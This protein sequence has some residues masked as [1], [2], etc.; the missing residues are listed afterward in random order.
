M[1]VTV[2]D[3]AT[4]RRPHPSDESV[5]MKACR[6]EPVPFTP[7][8]LMRQA[9]RYMK[10]Y[11]ELREQT[12][13]LDLCKSSQLVSE[14]TVHAVERIGADAAILFA[15]LLLPVEP[16]GLK[17]EFT[18]GDGPAITP[19]VRDAA[20]VDAL[21]EVDSDELSYVYDAVRQTRADLDDTTPLIGF[22]GAPFTI[23][24]YL[25]EGG[26]SRNYQHTKSL[27]Y[28]D[29]GAW[30]AL[31]GK[32]V[33]GQ[34]GFLNR[35]IRAG[36]QAVQLFDSWVGCL[37]PED[38]RRFVRPHSAA[39]IEG[40]TPGTPVIHFGTGTATLLPDMRAAGGSVLGL[41]WR[42]ELDRG[43]ETVGHDVAIMGN[44][45]PLALF[46]DEAHLRREVE[47]ILRQADGRPGHIFNLGHGILPQT[48]VDNV[49][50]LIEMVHELSKS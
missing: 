35:Q 50:R 24:S 44:L 2:T 47:R 17:L 46:G 42:V 3:P 23:A 20:A 25:V 10:E 6:R 19:P 43:W 48:P 32:V 1:G 26:G 45:D 28:R 14:V 31:M 37:S 22:A 34:I 9:G 15:D 29:E 4:S 36:A 38:Y 7:I 30:N 16:M 41:D 49:C 12:P 40:I 21:K 27:M 11:R 39:L 8:W 18:E 33:R 5:F 13:F